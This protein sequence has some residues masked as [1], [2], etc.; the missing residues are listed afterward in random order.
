MNKTVEQILDAQM[1]VEA[2]ISS[3]R[4]LD[5]FEPW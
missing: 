2:K 3:L 5:F 4:L 1:A